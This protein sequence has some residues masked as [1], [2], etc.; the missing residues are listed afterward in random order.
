[1]NEAGFTGDKNR[2]TGQIRSADTRL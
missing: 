2:Q 1:V